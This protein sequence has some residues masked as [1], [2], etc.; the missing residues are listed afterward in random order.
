MSA[1]R[2]HVVRLVRFLVCFDS[3][4]CEYCTTICKFR[5]RS[6]CGKIPT[7]SCPA[8][9]GRVPLLTYKH[10][11]MNRHWLLQLAVV[12]FLMAPHAAEAKKGQGRSGAN[13]MSG[14]FRRCARPLCTLSGSRAARSSMPKRW[15]AAGSCR[16]TPTVSF[17]VS[18]PRRGWRHPFP[19]TA[20][21]RIP[22]L[23]AMLSDTIFRPWR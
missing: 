5:G 19:D 4:R 18:A 8:G 7:L 22:E 12:V 13:R 10:K 21:G 23:R 11:P 9:C 15:T 17:R 20:G 2:P 3:T 6:D 14:L 1:V 16:W